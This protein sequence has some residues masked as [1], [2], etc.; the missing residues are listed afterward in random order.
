MSCTSR[1]NGIASPRTGSSASGDRPHPW[2]DAECR[3]T[4]GQNLARCARRRA[5]HVPDLPE[6]VVGRIEQR[7]HRAR[8]VRHVREV[9]RRVRGRHQHRRLAL[10]EAPEAGV[11]DVREPDAGAVE[12]GTAQRREFQAPVRHG[13]LPDP[14]H[15]RPHG[16]LGRARRERHVLGQRRVLRAEHVQVVDED[17]PRACCLRRCDDVGHRRGPRLSPDAGVVG[18]ADRQH[19]LRDPIERPANGVAVQHVAGYEVDASRQGSR[20]TALGDPHAIAARRQR[21]E[22]RP[23]HR[24]EPHHH[25]LA[26]RLLLS[27]FRTKAI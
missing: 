24:A 5:G 11:A 16:R 14:G 18:K 19:E 15:L 7:E 23:A 22:R 27:A 3:G 12:I 2:R 9:V 25:S 17:H 8:D 26:H 1:A 4:K 6:R 20:P 10:G 21:F 13:G